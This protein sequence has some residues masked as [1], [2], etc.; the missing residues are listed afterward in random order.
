MR[1]LWVWQSVLVVGILSFSA[2]E[3]RVPEE[4]PEPQV[5]EEEVVEVV[6]FPQK[7]WECTEENASR[8]RQWMEAYQGRHGER[9]L[10]SAQVAQGL[11]E[12]AGEL[13]EAPMVIAAVS[14][15]GFSVEGR[16]SEEL[17]ELA[18]L[19]SE[20]LRKAR[21]EAEIM[22]E[23]H[24]EWALALAFAADVRQERVAEVV[25]LLQ[26]AEG[27]DYSAVYLAFLAPEEPER[28]EEIPEELWA[29]MSKD[30]PQE[31]PTERQ[32]QLPDEPADKAGAAVLEKCP[33]LGPVM[34]EVEKLFPQ[35]RVDHLAQ[36]ISEAW[37]ECGCN[38]DL[39][40][41]VA[42]KM[43]DLQAKEKDERYITFVESSFDE[44]K[45]SVQQ[46]GDFT[47]ARLV[48]KRW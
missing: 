14:D 43:G 11:V 40:Y 44:L 37:L 1:Y 16:S 29:R 5:E 32:E 2:C 35:Q 41:L 28:V 38:F 45:S 10:V 22:G 6:A 13:P 42:V 33:A 36:G 25:E 7:D 18:V 31:P 46:E 48:E 12:R 9:M 17:D 34:D 23:E 27:V 24:E 15:D 47:W 26:G 20:R 19:L 8:A 4:I 21:A 39:E 30:Y 3:K